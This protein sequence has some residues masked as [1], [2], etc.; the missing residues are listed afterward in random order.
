MQIQ[1]HTYIHDAAAGKAKSRPNCNCNSSNS[2]NKKQ[3]RHRVARPGWCMCCCCWCWRWRR[4]HRSGPMTDVQSLPLMNKHN[5]RERPPHHIKLTSTTTTAPISGHNSQRFI[6]FLFPIVV[7]SRFCAI[8][9]FWQL[10]S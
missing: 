10:E 1:N 3:R 2:N 4:C 7:F 5:Q 6:Y 9:R 8:E